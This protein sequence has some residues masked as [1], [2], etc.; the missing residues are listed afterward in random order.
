MS[1][2]QRLSSTKITILLDNDPLDV[3]NPTKRRITEATKDKNQP[4][5]AKMKFSFGSKPK[6]APVKIS[7][8]KAQ[9]SPAEINKAVKPVSSNAVAAAFNA[10]E[11][12]EE[13]EMPVEARMKMRNLGK[14]TPVPSGPNSFGKSKIGFSQDYKMYERKLMEEIGD[15]DKRGNRKAEEKPS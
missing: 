15:P 1:G 4:P 9:K 11:E 14:N 10:D 3:P 13:E 2:D 7:L 5:A 8:Q 6:M 12:S